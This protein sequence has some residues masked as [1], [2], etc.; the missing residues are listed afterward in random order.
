MELLAT[1]PLLPVRIVAT[2]RLHRDPRR[3]RLR[4]AAFAKT[5]QILTCIAKRGTDGCI[6]RWLNS[7]DLVTGKLPARNR[8]RHPQDRRYY[9]G[10]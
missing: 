5:S 10:K 2:D 7:V 3:L 1:D 9:V 8:T 6:A 4:S